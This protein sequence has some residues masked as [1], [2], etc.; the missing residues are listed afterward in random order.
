MNR[1]GLSAEKWPDVVSPVRN[2]G[3]IRNLGVVHATA[4]KGCVIDTVLTNPIPTNF[5]FL[6]NASE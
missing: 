6:E 3:I 1:G 4:F 2:E 5:S